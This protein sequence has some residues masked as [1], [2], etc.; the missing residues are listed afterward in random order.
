LII[1][2]PLFASSVKTEKAVLLLPPITEKEMLLSLQKVL[3]KTIR[4]KPFG[5]MKRLSF[6]ITLAWREVYPCGFITLKSP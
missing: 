4:R 1:F 3:E 6:R 5:L 2:I